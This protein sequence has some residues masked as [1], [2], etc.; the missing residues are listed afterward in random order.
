MRI[1]KEKAEQF[2]EKNERIIASEK[3]KKIFFDNVFSEK[4]LTPKRGN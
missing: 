4:T 1:V 2:V 3:D